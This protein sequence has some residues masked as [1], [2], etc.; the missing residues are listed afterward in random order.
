[1]NKHQTFPAIQ[2]LKNRIQFFITQILS[3]RIRHQ[4]KS[5]TTFFYRSGNFLQTSWDIGKRQS[6]KISESIRVGFFYRCT[7]NVAVA[8]QSACESVVAWDEMGS[9]AGDGEVGF[10]DGEVVH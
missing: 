9:G 3:M 5:I 8:G 6:C 1:M 7:V 4:N 2:F 10:G